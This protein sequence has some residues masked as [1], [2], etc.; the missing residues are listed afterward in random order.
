EKVGSFALVTDISQQKRT[1]QALIAAKRKADEANRSKSIFLANMSHE[2][3]TPMNGILGLSQLCLQTDLSEKQKDYLLKIYS[4][5]NSLLNIIND[6]LDFS[7]V[8]ANK[9]TIENIPFRLETVLTGVSNLISPQAF[10][11]GLELHFDY[12][13]DVP[14]MLLGDPLRLGQIL[15]NLTDNAVK[16][17]TIGDVTL[18]VRSLKQSEQTIT[19]EFSIQ[20]SGIGMTEEQAESLFQPFT[21][22]DNSTTRRFGGTGLGLTIS[23]GLVEMMNG[24]MK[25][26]SELGTG[27]A[28]IFTAE[29]GLPA[30]NHRLSLQLPEEIQGRATLLVSENKTFLRIVERM[31]G[32]FGLEV[33]SCNS[34]EQ[35]LI[36]LQQF[37]RN[38]YQLLIADYNIS[39][40]DG[41]QFADFI[42][43]NEKIPR[44]LKVIL[45]TAMS[46][47]RNLDPRLEARIDG[48]ITKPF[49]KSLF[50]KKIFRILG[51][52]S[53]SVPVSDDSPRVEIAQA[54]SIRGSKILLVEDNEIN[55][56]VIQE[57]LEATGIETTLAHNGKQAL[58]K[59][60]HDTFDALLMDL[61]MPEMDGYEAAKRIR[62]ELKL[63]DL[64]IIAMTASAM[65]EDR[66]RCLA[67]GMNE[68][69]AKPIDI[70]LLLSILTLL[71][72]VNRK[73]KSPKLKM[74]RQTN[75]ERLLLLSSAKELNIQ[76]ALRRL[77]GNKDV[78]LKLLQ[79]F[80]QSYQNFGHQVE[81]ALRE[82]SPEAVAVML[83]PFKGLAGSIGAEQLRTRSGTLEKVLKQE[84]AWESPLLEFQRS[85]QLVL[86]N[87][88]PIIQPTEA[89]WEPPTAE[90]SDLELEVLQEVIKGLEIAVK[91]RK[92]LQCRPFVTKMG[93]LSWPRECRSS[94]ISLKKLIDKYQ[95]PQATAVITLLKEQLHNIKA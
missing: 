95:F 86:E 66:E 2:I 52:K 24:V 94:I 5:A 29:F 17:T 84:K 36:E 28:F 90:V 61:Q 50:F 79:S 78:Y 59:L 57:L 12:R 63:H 13:E 44:H 20:D 46:Y 11:K 74:S 75:N 41:L 82:K 19:L 93:T 76:E 6:I 85:L 62:E 89:A 38:P 33:T 88:V 26:T 31:L 27:S 3:R 15:T 47:E 87:L 54:V 65:P 48:V 32:S 7:K 92:P 56:Q 60:R 43:Q 23:K 30:N 53:D 91:S 35:A 1:E 51:K 73:I 21:Q 14:L 49:K 34:A 72:P 37:N 64:P 71:I 4:S 18:T 67:V 77:E 10:E 22:A 80:Y 69:I 42:H 68:H 55:Q 16:F 81:Q 39:A 70:H 40:T 58:E 25:V 45:V 9:V 83:H 8:E